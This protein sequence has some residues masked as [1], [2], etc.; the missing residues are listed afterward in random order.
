[1][2]D[3]GAGTGKLTR[4][5]VELGYE[6]V[7]VEPDRAMLAE[8]RRTAPTV[9]ALPGSAEAIPLPDGSV[10]A[11]LAGNAMHWFEMN[12]A[13]PEIARVLVAGGVVAGLW[14]LMDD[15][16]DW[17]AQLSRVAGAEAIGPRDTPDSWRVEAARLE[18]SMNETGAR[19]AAAEQALFPHGQR[20]TVDSLVATFSTK[21]GILVMTQAERDER[22][23]AIR[24]FLDG[25][26]ETNRGEFTLPMMTGVLRTRA[27]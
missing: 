4:T 26:A 6:V 14:N 23:A 16:V 22:L 5:L 19:F 13:S 1:V 25:R 21:A 20:R 27:A 24:T 10:D 3:L 12:A 15:R 9:A 2:L 18:R 8:L 7:A 17:V 11:V